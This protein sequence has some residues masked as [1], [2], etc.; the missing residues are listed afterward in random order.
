MKEG[1][2]PLRERRSLAEE[3]ES[4]ERDLVPEKASAAQRQEMRRSFYCGAIA[5]HTLMLNNL[6]EGM[7]ETAL[8][9]A[10][11]ESLHQ[12]LAQFRRDLGEGRA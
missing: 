6:D 9:L 3:W 5:I 1:A 4:F 8:D 12:E 11:I 10:Y 7:D 2:I